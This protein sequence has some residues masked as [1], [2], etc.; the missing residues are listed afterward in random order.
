MSNSFDA[1]TGLHERLADCLEVSNIGIVECYTSRKRSAR[2][3]VVC[4]RTGLVGIVETTGYIAFSKYLFQPWSN[5]PVPADT[6][7]SQ[8]R[9]LREGIPPIRRF[10]HQIPEKSDLFRI[11]RQ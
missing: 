3:L 8:I 1:L 11:I 5:G 10:F 7:L 4:K 2:V 9:R 6:V